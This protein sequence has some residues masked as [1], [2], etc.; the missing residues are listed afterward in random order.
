MPTNSK[1]LH[2]E[3]GFALKA[4]PAGITAPNDGAWC[5]M[6]AEMTDRDGDVVRVK[7]LKVPADG[8]P[9]LAQHM[10]K[11]IDGSPT[12]IGRL[13]ETK[14]SEIEYE[15]KNVPAKLGR[16]KWANTELANK[17]REL[18]PE[19]L[20]TVSIGAA[21]NDCEP[22]DKKNPFGGMD[23]KNTELFEL[24]LVTIPANAAATALRTIKEKLGDDLDI[25]Q[26]DFAALDVLKRIDEAIAQ[27]KDYTQEFQKLHDRFDLIESALVV[28]AKGANVPPPDDQK[29]LD[30]AKV[31]QVA[32]FIRS[33]V[34]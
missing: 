19:F 21:I 4:L 5:V 10:R 11:G 7:G 13:V 34:K 6:S 33:L 26:K 25:S 3:V 17:Y 16:F 15:G 1:T 31:K 18:W 30:E 2:K 27:I 23:Y 32:E 14:D 8:V 28:K 24:S 9:L 29:E 20:N 22:L 12:T